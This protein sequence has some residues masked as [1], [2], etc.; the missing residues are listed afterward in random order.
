MGR[1]GGRSEGKGDQCTFGGDPPNRLTAVTSGMD[2]SESAYNGLSQRVTIVEKDNGAIT[3][4]K[5]LVWV[6]SEIC[7]ERDASNTVTK[8]YYGQGVQ[9][10]STNYYYTRD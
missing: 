5:N 7:E 4:T 9:V 2:R 6:G 8:R 1:G 10:G 3:T